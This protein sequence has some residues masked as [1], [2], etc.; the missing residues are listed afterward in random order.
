M[1]L[2]ILMALA[3]SGCENKATAVDD[4]IEPQNKEVFQKGK[5]DTHG[6]K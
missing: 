2:L 3:N 1:I 5:I 6:T 4:T